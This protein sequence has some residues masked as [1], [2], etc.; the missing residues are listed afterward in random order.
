MSSVLGGVDHLQLFC[1]PRW[2]RELQEESESP[3]AQPA[4]NHSVHLGAFFHLPSAL[5]HRLRQQGI[6][7]CVIT[8]VTNDQK[9]GLERAPV[10]GVQCWCRSLSGVLSRKHH[11]AN[12]GGPCSLS[13]RLDAPAQPQHPGEFSGPSHLSPQPWQCRTPPGCH[14]TRRSILLLLR[15]NERGFFPSE[16]NFTPET[17]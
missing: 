15:S 10:Q 5:G 2:R 7:T 12:W 13:G 8:E 16:F 9:L 6:V 1:F 11:P 3:K 17:R 4:K 14:G